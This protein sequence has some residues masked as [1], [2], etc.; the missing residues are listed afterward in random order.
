MRCNCAVCWLIKLAFM[1]GTRRHCMA[2]LGS[3]LLELELAGWA[4]A[5]DD[6]AN[7][8]PSTLFELPPDLVALLASSAL[9][10]RESRAFRVLLALVSCALSSMLLPTFSERLAYVL[11]QSVLWRCSL[12]HGVCSAHRAVCICWV[13]PPATV[14]P[15]GP[16]STLIPPSATLSDC[17]SMLDCKGSR[18]VTWHQWLPCTCQG[19][20]ISQIFTR[21]HP[22]QS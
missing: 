10:S 12:L 14:D 5:D 8:S 6:N 18:G 3:Y 19:T 13:L 17:I 16:T 4:S 9:P 22:S 15:C 2:V 20:P 7:L 1:Q 11:A 21:A